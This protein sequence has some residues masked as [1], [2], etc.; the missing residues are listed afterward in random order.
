MVDSGNSTGWRRKKARSLTGL[1]IHQR[2]R[3][4]ETTL[5]T[6]RE[7]SVGISVIRIV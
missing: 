4:E 7:R 2:R 5:I 6:L 3:M 1:K